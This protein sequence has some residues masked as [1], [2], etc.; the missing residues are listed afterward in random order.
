M[1]RRVIISIVGCLL[2]GTAANSYAQD[3]E[4]KAT[5][6]TVSKDRVR[7]NGRLYYSHVVL[8]KQTLFSISKA[9]GV[10]LQDIYDSNPTLNLETEGLKTY[11]ILLIPAVEPKAQEEP[12][13]SPQ[14]ETKSQTQ[15]N[16][17]SAALDKLKSTIKTKQE[18]YQ[19][20]QEERAQKEAE[21]K[22]QK[23]KEQEVKAQK[24]AEARAQKEA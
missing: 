14:T 22:A 8:E 16:P 19:A 4:Y 12:A 2:L 20:K 17:I 1:K 13:P 3:P 15:A 18:D 7:Q 5:P 6:V 11:Q 9:Y 24:E 23:E 10:T 21:I